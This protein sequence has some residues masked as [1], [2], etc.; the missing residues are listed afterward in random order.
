MGPEFV[1]RLHGGARVAIEPLFQRSVPQR[2]VWFPRDAVVCR[3]DQLSAILVPED[4]HVSILVAQL[5]DLGRVDRQLASATFKSATVISKV[6]QTVDSV[7]ATY[8]SALPDPPR[9]P[10]IV[11]FAEAFT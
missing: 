8:C 6:R 11:V 9:R 1:Q 2:V 7:E 10:E 4:R 3:F 5:R